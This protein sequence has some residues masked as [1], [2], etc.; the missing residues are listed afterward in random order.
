M[1]ETSEQME[2]TYAAEFTWS[3]KTTLLLIQLYKNRKESFRNPKCKKRLLWGQIKNEFHA[4]G[5]GG[6]TEE[7]L[8][9]KFRNLKKTYKSIKDNNK[10]TQTG[11]G[12]ITWEFYEEFDEIFFDDRTINFGP[13]LSSLPIP[14]DSAILPPQTTTSLPSTSK[15][16]PSMLASILTPARPEERAPSTPMHLTSV[17]P[18]M[19]LDPELFIPS[20]SSR[21]VPIPFSSPNYS[22]SISMPG[23]SRTPK[24]SN[25][26][27]LDLKI[28]RS[29][30]NT[31]SSSKIGVKDKGK[32]LH[33]HRKKILEIEIRRTNELQKIREAI[34]KSNAIQ[35]E[36]NKILTQIL[37]KNN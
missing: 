13:T 37:N 34:E 22:S 5:Y 3:R 35:E 6:V 1:R 8:D 32:R 24:N 29:G 18:A 31:P 23:P 16:I 14:N 7:I 12:R 11:R 28:S 26:S 25:R 4:K 27:E 19:S 30:P 36:R 10:K 17:T 21:T 9:R 20:V 2:C 15:V 33:E